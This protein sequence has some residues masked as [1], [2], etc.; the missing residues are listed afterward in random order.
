MSTMSRGTPSRDKTH[1][2]IR[3]RALFVSVKGAAVGMAANAGE[4]TAITVKNTHRLQ[5]AIV[6]L[7]ERMEARLNHGLPANDMNTPTLV[8][9]LRNTLAQMTAPTLEM[10]TAVN[11]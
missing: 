2:R 8:D 11:D 10:L 3:E 4:C 7:L 1:F 6:P 9:V 5:D